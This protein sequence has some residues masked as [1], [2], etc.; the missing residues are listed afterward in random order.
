MSALRALLSGIVD[1]AGLYPPAALDME[2][3][4]RNYDAYADGPLSWMLGRFV[5]GSSRLSE[6][7]KTEHAQSS[8]R[9]P[10]PLSVVLG[11]QVDAEVASVHAFK[12][13]H[14]DRFTIHSVEARFTTEEAIRSAAALIDSEFELF[15]ELPIDEDPL[16]L[17]AAVARSGVSAKV[18]T[19]GVTVEAF[20]APA[21]VVRFIRRCVEAKVRLKATAGLHH[22]LCSEYPLTYEASSPRGPLFGH[23]N[24]FLAAGFVSLGMSDADALRVLLER[25]ASSITSSDAGI[26]WRGHVLSTEQI[27]CLRQNVAVSFGSCSFREPVDELR[28]LLLLS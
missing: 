12:S 23:L 15:A 16:P 17:V 14:G 18:R 19:G 13:A 10:I 5:V 25:D 7:A 24:V 2:A 21:H 1:Y 20:P 26:S 11:S 8:S 22:P 28:A 4:V 27:E 6:L 3:A 9:G